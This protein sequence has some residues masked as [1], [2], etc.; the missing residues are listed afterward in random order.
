MV[1]K[2]HQKSLQISVF[3]KNQKDKI[4]ARFMSKAV[5]HTPVRGRALTPVTSA[6]C[7]AKPEFTTYPAETDKV[8]PPS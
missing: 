1:I 7:R 2:A 8:S 4:L 3:T 6:I 5:V